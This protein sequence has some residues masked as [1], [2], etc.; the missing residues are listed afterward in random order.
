MST[1]AY[2]PQDKSKKL[3]HIDDWVVKYGPSITGCCRVCNQEVFVKADKS[4]KQT[5]FAHSKNSKCPT[6]VTNHKPFSIFKDMPRDPSLALAA[7]E[8]TLRNIDNVYQKLKKFVPA[9]TWK[10]L[11][12]LLY[13]AGKEDVWSLKGMPKHYIPYVLLT[14]TEK[15]EANKK[16]QRSKAMF[17]VLEPSPEETVYWNSANLKKRYIWEISLP[18]REVIHYEIELETPVA[19]YIKKAE[20]LLW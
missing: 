6:I 19:W 14:C 4:Q 9:L 16:F 5:H 18:S 8:W 12:G 17:F 13:V 7:K 20:S 10:E 2:H 11:H 3:V 15:F 1:F